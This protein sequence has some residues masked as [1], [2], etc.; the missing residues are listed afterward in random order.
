MELKIKNIDLVRVINF[1]DGLDLKG[2]K[3]I[4]RTKLSMLLQDKLQDV[5]KAEKQLQEELKDD[6]SQL[7]SDLKQLHD[8]FAV[9]DDGDSRTMLESV[10]NTVK[11]VIEKEEE[12]FKFDDAY[13]ITILYDAFNL[14]AE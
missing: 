6:K 4:H 7:E 11:N 10:K 3:S 14:D 1:L 5:I 12:S 9:I 8:D 13:A 2:L